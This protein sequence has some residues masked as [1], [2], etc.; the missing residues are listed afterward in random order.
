DPDYRR[1]ILFRSTETDAGF[2]PVENNVDTSGVYTDTGLTNDTTYFYRMMAVDDDGHRS[3]VSPSVSATPKADPFPPAHVAVLINDG[4]DQ[5]ASRQVTLSFFYEEPGPYQ[6]ATEVLV[7][8]DPTFSGAEDWQ[9]FETSMPWILASGLESGDVATV[10]AKF[11]DDA[12]NE[13]PDIAGD[14]IEFVGKSVYLYLPAVV[15]Q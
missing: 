8:N 4:D 10:Y 3:A 14:S 7:S 13:S 2:V 11:R 1:L 12:H 5:T 9:D 6:D 15:R